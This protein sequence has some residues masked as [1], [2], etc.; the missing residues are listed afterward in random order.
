[1]SSGSD[2]EL[3]LAAP[4][5]SSDEE[6]SLPHGTSSQID[7]FKLSPQKRQ[8]TVFKP[9]NSSRLRKK[10]KK[11]A[12][13]IPPNSLDSLADSQAASAAQL[14]S[15][16]GTPCNIFEEDIWGLESGQIFGEDG[17]VTT[18]ET[19]SIGLEGSYEDYLDAVYAGAAGFFRLEHD[20][21]AVQG[22]D[23]SKSLVKIRIYYLFDLR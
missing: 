3:V 23:S 17:P 11:K 16:F 14:S 4:T 2:D 12:R 9:G 7:D 15:E 22:W 13:N 18:M 5:L 20:L 10:T 6:L 1:M 19:G 21:F 8:R